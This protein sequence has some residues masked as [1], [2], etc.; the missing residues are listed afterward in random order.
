MQA[1]SRLSRRAL[2][3]GSAA[4]LVLP[5]L[6][7]R[8]RAQSPVVSEAAW[9]ELNRR[10]TGGV[11]RPNDPRFVRLTQPENLRYYNPLA[12]PGLKPDPDAPFGVVR[13]R[14]PEEV[15]YAITWA[16][17]NNLP[18]VPR[19]GGHSYAGCST[20]PGLVIHSGAMQRVELNADGVIEAG[21]GSLFGHM[22]A[23]L[24]DTRDEKARSETGRHTITHGRCGGVGLSAYLMGGGLA[25]DSPHAGMGC[26]RVRQVEIV[27]AN[28][29]VVRASE[30]ERQDLFWAVRGG[31]GGNLGFATKWWLNPLPADRV[32]A[33]SGIYR[34]SGHAQFV[35]RSLLRA[36][37]AAPDTMGAE[38]TVSA[39]SATIKSPW[40]Y[41]IKF[42]CQLH[43]SREEFDTLMGP[44]L[45]AAAVAESRDCAVDGC[46]SQDLR[47]LPSWDA[48]EFFE[49]QAVPNRYQETSL[50]ARE[51]T[52]G[53][54]DEIFRIWPTWPGSVAAARLSIYRLG[55][56][57]NT[58]LPDAT[59][60]VHRAARWLVSTDIDWTGREKQQDVDDNLKWQRNVHNTF[61]M[62]LGRPGSYQN[63]P[64]PGLDNHAIAYWGSN[65]WRLLQVKGRYDPDFV[66]TPPRNQGIVP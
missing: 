9:W 11:L 64:D 21:G 1:K 25:L 10:I 27:L 53:F 51:V 33:F 26:D 30:N 48:Q 24:R 7:R 49:I 23:A 16:R 8:S 36:I 37:D 50:F 31:G 2:L 35:F 34:L 20:V 42:V 3:S 5:V 38:I 13:P 52:D 43:G 14:T 62:M 55:G 46:S 60:Y 18:M 28:G 61:S 32:V 54:I 19:S 58:I 39:S 63:F 12:E 45:A 65:Y 44:A 22:L 66:F 4:S 59:A 6:P 40:H 57:V 56:K 17:D 47:E 29:E 41:E 15:A